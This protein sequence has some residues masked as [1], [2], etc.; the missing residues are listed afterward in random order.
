MPFYRRKAP[1]RCHDGPRIKVE[2]FDSV[3]IFKIRNEGR[4]V[5]YAE[6]DATPIRRMT[7]PVLETAFANVL[8]D[9]FEYRKK[10]G[11]FRR[12]SNQAVVASTT[13]SSD[14]KTRYRFLLFDQSGALLVQRL[15]EEIQKA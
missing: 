2:G 14:D 3:G 12:K 9:H 8:G 6:L 11:F 10:D 5:P 4:N 7:D 1:A 13:W 15:M